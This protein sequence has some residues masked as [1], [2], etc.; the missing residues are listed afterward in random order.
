MGGGG[1]GGG[2]FKAPTVGTEHHL[3]IR[4]ILL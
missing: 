3:N 4:Y 2:I 1:G